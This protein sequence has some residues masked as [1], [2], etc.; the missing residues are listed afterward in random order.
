MLKFSHF[1]RFGNYE[2]RESFILNLTNLNDISTRIYSCQF[3]TQSL[4]TLILTISLSIGTR[5]QS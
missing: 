1:K 4:T 2:N 5:L 3:F